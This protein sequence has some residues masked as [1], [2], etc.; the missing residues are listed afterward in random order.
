MQPE[1]KRI[2]EKHWHYGEHSQ[3]NAW[4]ISAQ[5]PYSSVESLGSFPDIVIYDI[6][7]FLSISELIIT[8]HLVCKPF[9]QIISILLLDKRFLTFCALNESILPTS[10]GITWIQIVNSSRHPLDYLELF[11][12]FSLILE[13]ATAEELASLKVASELL[14]IKKDIHRTMPEVLQSESSR[15][16]LAKVLGC[17]A[18]FDPQVGYCQG[19]N[20]LAA[21]LLCACNRNPRSAFFLLVCLMQDYQLRPLFLSESDIV[22]KSLSQVQLCFEKCCPQLFAHFSSLE[23][24]L[25][26]FAVV[27]LGLLFNLNSLRRNGFS[28][29]ILMTYRYRLPCTFGT[30]F[31]SKAGM[32]LSSR[33]PRCFQCMKTS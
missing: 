10:R 7:S 30:C 3:L 28:R 24:D 1:V 13:K 15:D 21:T 32:S 33:V 19:L 11:D 17:Y 14:R 25:T 18:L 2:L 29:Y 6:F 9:H 23:I 22:I 31:W 5:Q 16:S 27:S 8:V 26:N 4:R 12:R 20:Y